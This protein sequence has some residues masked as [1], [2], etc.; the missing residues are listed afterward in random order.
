[1]TGAFRGVNDATGT[2]G[3]LCQ[4]HFT[5]EPWSF[6]LR[7]LDVKVRLLLERYG[8][9]RVFSEQCVCMYVRMCARVCVGLVVLLFRQLYKGCLIN[10]QNVRTR[11]VLINKRAV[12]TARHSDQVMWHIPHGCWDR[13]PTVSRVC[14]HYITHNPIIHV[15]RLFIKL[16]LYIFSLDFISHNKRAM[17]PSPWGKQARPW[18]WPIISILCRC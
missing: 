8:T 4:F 15:V 1:M 5:E 16:P 3:H 13:H 12:R 2:S 17:R 6:K 7:I 18:N 11:G 9:E 14:L 10:N